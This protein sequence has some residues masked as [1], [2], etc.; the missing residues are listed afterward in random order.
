MKRSVHGREQLVAPRERARE[1]QEPEE[2]RA[3]QAREEQ[4]ARRAQEEPL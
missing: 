2:E 4:E 1:Y 3:Q